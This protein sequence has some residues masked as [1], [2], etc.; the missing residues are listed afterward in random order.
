[1]APPAGGEPRSVP[2]RRLL[3]RAAGRFVCDVETVVCAARMG[4][5][6]K[7][8][9]TVLRSW[10]HPLFRVGAGALRVRREI[11]RHPESPVPLQAFQPGPE[12]QTAC[13]EYHTAPYLQR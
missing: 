4:L 13:S 6:L 5:F 1:M 2:V 8:G 12:S 11:A 3:E 9:G 7:D 10:P